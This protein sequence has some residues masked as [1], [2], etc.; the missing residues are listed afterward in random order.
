VQ[1]R[2]KKHGDKIAVPDEDETGSNRDWNFQEM[3][4]ISNRKGRKRLK[5][6]AIKI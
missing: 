2:A 4:S 5:K 6:V 1:K 3:K